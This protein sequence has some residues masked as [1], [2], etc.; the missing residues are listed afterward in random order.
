MPV[1][2]LAADWPAPD[3]VCAG[4]TRRQAGASEH[5]FASLNLATHV[6]D[7]PQAVATNRLRF[8][9]QCALPSEPVWIR[10]VHGTS[11]AVDPAPLAVP[12]ADA[13]VGRKPGMVC[14]VLTADCLPVV[15]CAADGSEIAAAH[16][17]WRGLLE[18]VLEATVTAMNAPPGEILAWLGP[19][20]SQPAFEVG[21]EVREQFVARNPAAE[22]Y[23]LAND[24]ARWQADLCGLARQRLAG[25]GVSR[26]YGGDYCT[27]ADAASFFSYRRDGECGRM[28]TFVFRNDA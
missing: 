25:A 27:Y 14:A 26:V 24:N 10:Q 2:W 9:Q 1:S 5:P 12:Q 17:G 8:R 21:N 23:F 4:T 19:A 7:D 28:A 20:I 15:F 18:G 13:I 6:G 11:V 16:A 3:G 22:R